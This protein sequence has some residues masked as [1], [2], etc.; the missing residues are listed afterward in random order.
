MDPKKIIL[1]PYSNTLAHAGRCLILAGEL[2]KRGHEVVLAGSPKYLQ[3]PEIVKENGISFYNLPEIDQEEGL[4]ILRT[5]GK[6]LKRSTVMEHI[7]AELKMFEVLKPHLIITDFRLTTYISARKANI[8]VVSLLGGRWIEKYSR[9]KWKAIK[10]FPQ[11][12][13]IKKTLGKEGAD[14]V[15]PFFQHLLHR[16]KSWPLQFAF[17]KYG[18]KRRKTPGDILIGDF[19]LIL[20]TQLCCPSKD[21]P[22]NFR[23][24][25]PIYW[26]PEFPPPAWL[27]KIDRKRPVI[28]LTLG[29]TGHRDLFCELFKIFAGSNYQ[30]LLSTGGQVDFSREEIPPNIYL[31]KYMPGETIM[32][33]ADL[34]IYHGGSGTSYQTIKT[35]TPAIVIATHM[36]QEFM[37]EAVEHH[38]VGIFLTMLEVMKNPSLILESTKKMFANLETYKKNMETLKKDLRSYNPV[39]AAADGI[40]DFLRKR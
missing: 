14:R 11:Y 13:L 10:N 3:D 28:Y 15:M 34:V 7:D 24:V 5:L 21:L 38:Q 16:Y 29:S 9:E 8:P 35:G 36:E 25:G 23:V 17:K 31:E 12:P 4:A 6:N 39:K 18:L 1:T 27:E 37:G 19:N 33:L 40:E 2:K 26:E 30:I 32:E 22:E 20:D